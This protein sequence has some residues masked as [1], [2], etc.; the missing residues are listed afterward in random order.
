LAILD[1]QFPKAR[2]C[3]AKW[4]ADFWIPLNHLNFG[5]NDENRTRI[6]PLKFSKIFDGPSGESNLDPF[7]AWMPSA[8]V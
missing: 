5:R 4:L 7:G 6:D 2:Q 8:L 1:R 3:A